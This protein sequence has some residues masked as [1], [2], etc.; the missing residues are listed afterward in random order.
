MNLEQAKLDFLKK[1]HQFI[2]VD[3]E[4]NVLESCNSLVDIT[5][6]INKP[7]EYG[8][9]FL[10]SHVRTVKDI[11]FGELSEID[12]VNFSFLDRKGTYD[13]RISKMEV[14][15]TERILIVVEDRT[16]HYESI[17]KIQQH[18]NEL[19]LDKELILMQTEIISKRNEDIKNLIKETHHRIK[20]NLQVINSLLDFQSREIKDPNIQEI[21]KQAQSRV[22]SMS[23]LHEKL[24]QSY[25]LKD[26]NVE[27]YIKSLIHEIIENYDIE[28]NVHCDVIVE[29]F[30]IGAKTLVPLGLLL[31]ELVT[32]SLK[33]GLKNKKDGKINVSLEQIVGTEYRLT[34]ADNGIGIPK[35]FFEREP[36][37]LGTELIQIFADQLSGKVQILD[38]PGGVIRIDFSQID[39]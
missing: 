34:V 15:D 14:D 27:E 4:G 38:E 29:N 18:K 16:P 20:N 36:E 1:N 11:N 26:V 22:Y 6:L 24:Y 7:L 31:N 9:P 13:I 10:S 8:I 3:M 21:F 33:H 5:P 37:S 35:D 2:L 12:C 17:L 39:S 30:D 19:T 28:K 32:N 23:L 25:N